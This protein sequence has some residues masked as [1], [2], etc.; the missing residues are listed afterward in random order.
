MDKILEK[1]A[2]LRENLDELA[3]FKEYK[4]LKEVIQKDPEIKELKKQ[5]VRAK[6]ENR[7]EDH[8]RLLDEYNSHPLIVNFGVIENEVKEY[9]KEVSDILN[10]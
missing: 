7:L 6:N 9:L 1:T 10:N 5:I 8:K 2:V 4:S 3:I